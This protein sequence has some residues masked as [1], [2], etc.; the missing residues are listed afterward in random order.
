MEQNLGGAPSSMM[1]MCG[2]TKS[3]LNNSVR[4]FN[5]LCGNRCEKVYFMMRLKLLHWMKVCGDTSRLMNYEMIEGEHQVDGTR[6]LICI[7]IYLW[8]DVDV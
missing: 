1:K 5:Y 6:L 2:T 8:I 3:T 7:Y 4:Y